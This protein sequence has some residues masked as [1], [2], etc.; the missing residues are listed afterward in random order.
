MHRIRHTAAAALVAACAT[1]ALAP[2]RASAAP[3]YAD[4][5]LSYDPGTNRF[6]FSAYTN[7]AAALGAPQTNTGFGFVTTPFN[8][9]FSKNDVVSVGLGGQITLRLARYAEPVAGAPEIGVFT[10]QQFVQT[11]TGGTSSAPSLFYPSQKA[12]VDVSA[13]GTTWVALNSGAVTSFDIPANAFTDPAAQHPS[14]YGLPFTGGLD[15]LKNQPTLADTLA[16]YNGTGGGT[17]LD[18]SDTGLP[19][20]AYVRFTV[21]ATDPFSFQ[22]ESLSVSTASAGAPVPEPGAL[23]LAILGVCVVMR[24]RPG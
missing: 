7:P 24:R 19:H 10:F 11:A 9:P 5:V 16:A 6:Q 2:A 1:V 14:D 17:W 23:V 21:P 15:A 4:Q 20:V 12:Q 18:I 22:L 3:A 8:N 13:D